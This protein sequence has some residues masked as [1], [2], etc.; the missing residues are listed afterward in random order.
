MDSCSSRAATQPLAAEYQQA[1]VL[2]GG[3]EAEDAKA[4]KTPFRVLLLH[5]T[6][7]PFHGLLLHVGMSLI[8]CFM[9]CTSMASSSPLFFIAC[10]LDNEPSYYPKRWLSTFG[11]R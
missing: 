9:A 10:N 3:A 6:D 1:V 8:L 7:P 5:V 4:W 11:R 2:P